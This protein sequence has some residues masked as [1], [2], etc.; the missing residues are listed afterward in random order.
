MIGYK[1]SHSDIFEA[2]IG[3]YSFTKL[4]RFIEVKE[5]YR[6]ILEGQL[7]LDLYLVDQHFWHLNITDNSSIL[8]FIQWDWI[9]SSEMKR[10]HQKERILQAKK[11]ITLIEIPYW[12][13]FQRPTSSDSNYS[14]RKS[15]TYFHPMK[16]AIQ[17]QANH[18]I[19][20]KP[21]AE[22]K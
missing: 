13:D 2:Q 1:V 14:P 5:N 21:S 12:W 10:D 8:I 7:E 11:G 15:Q 9:M 6:E 18:P 4:Q 3:S 22:I 16:V 20:S 19:P 17:Y